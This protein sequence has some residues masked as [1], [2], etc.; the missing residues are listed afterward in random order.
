MG[1]SST[2]ITSALTSTTKATKAMPSVTLTPTG[3]KSGKKRNNLGKPVAPLRPI[4][5]QSVVNINGMKYLVVPHPDPSV[6]SGSKKKEGKLPIV[7]K[8]ATQSEYP[9]FEVEEDSNGKLTLLPLGGNNRK[10]LPVKNPVM[11]DFQQVLS[12]GFTAMHQVFK[13]LNT[14]DRISAGQVCKFWYQISKSSNLWNSVSLKNCRVADWKL[15]RDQLNKNGTKNLDMR[16]MHF[17]QDQKETW[18][19][20]AENF[21]FALISLESLDLPKMSPEAIHNIVE[22]A[23][24]SPITNLKCLKANQ[25]TFLE[26]ELNFDLISGLENLQEL[27]LK[28]VSGELKIQDFPESFQKLAKMTNLKTL[29][30]LSLEKFEIQHL[31]IIT[32]NLTD[33][34]HLVLGSCESIEPENL[35]QSL[36]KLTKLKTL[37]LEKGKFDINIQLLG[38]LENLETLELIDF[39][40]ALGFGPGLVKLQNVR[41]LLLIPVYTDE[42][43]FD[44][45]VFFKFSSFNFFFRWQL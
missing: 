7:L 19:S 12:S 15:L 20:C 24:N 16:R 36:K 5:A 34:E 2:T 9:S 45:T 17:A 13:Y 26:Q 8:P 18:K 6:K 21:M 44:F 10:I 3:N 27:R 40:M 42:V 38:E 23:N 31:E 39:E 41:K 22:S 37:R 35:F 29:G 11:K 25:I 30:L 28:S 4:E 32:E 1:N 33:L 14:K 43:I